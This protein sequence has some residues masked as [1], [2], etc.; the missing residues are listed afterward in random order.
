MIP[1][2]AHSQNNKTIGLGKVLLFS[3]GNYIQY[4]MINHNGGGYKEKS[5][6]VCVTESACS[7]SE[8]NTTL[9]VN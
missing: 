1:F 8:I 3:P 4:P 2:I 9:S 6:C 7:T 5:L